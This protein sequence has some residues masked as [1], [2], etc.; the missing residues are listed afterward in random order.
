TSSNSIL[1]RRSATSTTSSRASSPIKRERGMRYADDLPLL[2]RSLKDPRL[3]ARLGPLLKDVRAVSTK[4]HI[5]PLALKEEIE[6]LYS[7]FEAIS[8]DMF[9]GGEDDEDESEDGHNQ[10]KVVKV[11]DDHVKRHRDRLWQLG[12]ICD[13][14][15][16]CSDPSRQTFEV[17]W[18]DVVHSPM[19]R[20]ACRQQSSLRCRN[21]TS[22][23]VDGRYGDAA[24]TVRRG[25]GGAATATLCDCRIDFGIFLAP[26]E[27][28]DLQYR[29]FDLMSRDV[30]QVRQ[31][32]HLNAFEPDWP[33]AVSVETKRLAPGVEKASGQLA[34]YGRAQV[35][36]MQ[37]FPDP[38]VEETREKEPA[39]RGIRGGSETILP[40]LKVVSAQW[41]L[42]FIVREGPNAVAYGP[43]GLG[44]TAS[45]SGCYQVFKSLCIL[46]KWAER[47]CYDWWLRHISVT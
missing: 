36:L 26:P 43:F 39:E 6:A 46:F 29:I 15:E 7:P 17:E 20:L 23:Q 45:L 3:P 18:N 24:R 41:E 33:L 22:V 42:S 11:N 2:R 30:D 9:F 47:E 5:M 34:S 25:G 31:L 21:L 38:Q 28:S 19:L 1:S 40:Q 16:D 10:S 32:N 37:Q 27:K 14:T 44:N 8:D 13:G 12:R 35:R 4:K